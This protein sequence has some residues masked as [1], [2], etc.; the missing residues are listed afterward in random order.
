MGARSQAR[1]GSRYAAATAAIQRGYCS[2]AGAVGQLGGGGLALEGGALARRGRLGRGAL[3]RRRAL[4]GRAEEGVDLREVAAR[5]ALG[6]LV[7]EAL[8]G[9]HVARVDD[10]LQEPLVERAVLHHHRVGAGVEHEVREEVPVGAPDGLFEGGA[11][12]VGLAAEGGRRAG[13]VRAH[14]RVRGVE[15]VRGVELEG[16]LEAR[17]GVGQVGDRV[18]VFAV[19]ADVAT[20]GVAGPEDDRGLLGVVEALEV[21]APGVDA[22][23][24]RALGAAVVALFHGQGLEADLARPAV[25][26]RGPLGVVLHPGLVVVDLGLFEP[27]FEEREAV[28]AVGAHEVHAQRYV[29]RHHQEQALALGDGVRDRPFGDRRVGEGVHRGRCLLHHTHGGVRREL[30][31]AVGLAQTQGRRQDPHEHPATHGPIG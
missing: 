25:R 1:V 27:V 7:R 17:D 29:L 6:D 28:G 24:H 31:E 23:A 22:A 14:G 11:R 8:L 12:A 18:G 26:H 15:V 10:L 30:G 4:L 3:A 19:E 9:H 16:A 5:A 13:V 21:R 2:G 20:H